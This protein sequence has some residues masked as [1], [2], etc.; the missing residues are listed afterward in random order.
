MNLLSTFKTIV[1]T[2]QAHP[3]WADMAATKEDSPWHREDSV[4]IHTVMVMDEYFM[5]LAASGETTLTRSA[6]LG[7]IACLFHDFGKP[8]CR[9]V[10]FKPERGH[11]NAFHGHEIVSARMWEDFAAV[12]WNTLFA[13][14]GVSPTDIAKVGLMIEHHLPYDT[15]DQT[16]RK[17]LALTIIEYFGDAT[18]F[19]SVLKADTWGRI[20]DDHPVKKEKVA[21]WC[22]DF[23]LLCETIKAAP[24]KEAA[25]TLRADEFSNEQWNEVEY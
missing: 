11:Y 16:K 4:A 23:T 15:K 17:Q 20:S 21:N 12:N 19:I 5:Q 1:E 13:P 18:T 2:A 6:L 7:A 24:E 9:V 22:F 3:T 25:A 10:K 8:V 14:V